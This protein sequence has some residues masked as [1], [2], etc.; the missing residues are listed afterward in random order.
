VP[1]YVGLLLRDGGPSKEFM[2]GRMFEFASEEAF[3]D[4]VRK[5]ASG[6]PL[7]MKDWVQGP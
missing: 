7:E 4:I 6:K 3:D 2:L 1:V 5:D